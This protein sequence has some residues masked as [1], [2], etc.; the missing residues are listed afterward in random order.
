M[1]TTLRVPK[2]SVS[3]QEGTLLS[4]LAADGA[5][6]VEGQPLYTLE[7]EKTTLDVEAPTAGVLR[8]VGVEGTTYKV[9]DIIG[10]IVA[11]T[12]ST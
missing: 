4:W 5:P 7:I 8:H 11:G 10:E 3:M 1:S 9:G 6:V 12:H 2:A